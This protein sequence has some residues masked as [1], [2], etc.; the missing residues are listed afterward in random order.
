MEDSS[1]WDPLGKSSAPASD[2]TF[3]TLSQKIDYFASQWEHS[4]SKQK[5]VTL[6]C[7]DLGSHLKF[8]PHLWNPPHSDVSEPHSFSR[9]QGKPQACH[10]CLPHTF[11]TLSW[12]WIIWSQYYKKH[13]NNHARLNKVVFHVQWS[14]TL[15]ESQ[16]VS[17]LVESTFSLCENR[18]NLAKRILPLCI[19]GPDFNFYKHR[20]LQLKATE[21]PKEEATG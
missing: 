16:S 1:C 14:E 21:R 17:V 19:W 6:L 8:G 5:S 11:R 12:H 7:G 13:H 10:N 15:K 3:K 9:R 18:I 20:H 4:G 2:S